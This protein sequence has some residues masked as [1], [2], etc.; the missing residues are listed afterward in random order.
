MENVS[1]TLLCKDIIETR[2][3]QN[4]PIINFGLG[5][6]PIKQPSLFSEALKKHASQKSYTSCEGIPELNHTLKT[7]YHTKKKLSMIF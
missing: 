6:N 4:L 7:I 1:P 2:K 5:E 3:K